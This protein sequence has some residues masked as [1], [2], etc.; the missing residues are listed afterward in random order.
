[1]KF[2]PTFLLLQRHEKKKK[3]V[4]RYDSSY[5]PRTRL[6]WNRGEGFSLPWLTCRALMA[7]AGRFT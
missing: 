4:C 5:Y 2:T 1:L 6:D 7:S 3:R